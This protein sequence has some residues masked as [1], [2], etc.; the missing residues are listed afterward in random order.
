MTRY[1]HFIRLLAL[2]SLVFA[3]L[4]LTTLVS[5]LLLL[6]G[7]ATVPDIMDM[8]RLGT[9][10]FTPGM[11]RVLLA[12]QHL[13]VF[14]LPGVV[15]AILFY[16]P[17]YWK[18]LGLGI[19][20]QVNHLLLGILFLVAAYPL[21][22][23]SFLVNESFPLPSWAMDLEGQAEETLRAILQMDSIWIFLFN[24]VII[25]ILPGIGEELIFRGIVQKELSAIVRSPVAGIWLAAF[26]FSAIHMQFEGFLPRM[27]LGVVLGYL[28]H[29]TGNLW[30]P[31]VAH[32]FN[33]GVQ[34]ALIYF[35]GMD[36]SQVDEQSSQLEWWMLPLSIGIMYFLTLRILKSNRVAD[37]I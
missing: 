21:V 6:A 34:I 30:V 32:A 1:G 12:A 19:T 15:F 14:I 17:A 31:I 24:L 5:I 13:L 22:N 37:T 8:S 23:L 28:Y 3:G 2:L 9:S 25:S 11:T 16:R 10:A 26:I 29:W 18:G 27:T 4:V 33:N 20:P 35:T 7:G 36:I